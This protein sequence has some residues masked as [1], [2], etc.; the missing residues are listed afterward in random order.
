MSGPDSPEPVMIGARPIAEHLF[1]DGSLSAQQR[2]ARLCKA[3]PQFP[4]RKIGRCYYARASA[5]DGWLRF[6]VG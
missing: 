1:G 5:L 3:D 2:V 6:V 4:V